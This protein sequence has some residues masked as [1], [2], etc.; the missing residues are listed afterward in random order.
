MPSGRS[1]THSVPR[2]LQQAPRCPSPRTGFDS[3]SVR[4]SPPAPLS[5]GSQRSRSRPPSKPWFC[6]AAR[7]LQRSSSSRSSSTWSRSG[8]FWAARCGVSSTTARSARA[9]GPACSATRATATTLMAPRGCCTC[10]RCTPSRRAAEAPGRS[11]PPRRGWRDG[12]CSGTRSSPSC[13]S[14]AGGE[15]WSG[16]TLGP[17]S[18]LSSARSSCPRL[19]SPRLRGAPR[20]ADCRGARGPASRSGPRRHSRRWQRRSALAPPAS[21][22]AAAGASCRSRQNGVAGPL[23]SSAPAAPPEEGAPEPW[24]RRAST[25]SG[26]FRR[27]RLSAFGR[28]WLWTACLIPRQRTTGG[29][30]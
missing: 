11:T 8:P 3:V 14:T 19:A 25:C 15:G 29:A 13:A 26:A 20:S 18:S 6:A 4:S 23:C 27:S 1:A 21:R 17:G 2:R 22:T 5:E 7:R 9:C 12:P 28:H 16:R 30:A 24:S 10:R